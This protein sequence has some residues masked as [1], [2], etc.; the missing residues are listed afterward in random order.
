MIDGSRGGSSTV[1]QRAHN[2]SGPGSIPGRP[3]SRLAGIEG[4]RAV[5]ALSILVYHVYSFGGVLGGPGSK[6]TQ[7]HIFAQLQLGVTLFFALS[8]F[9]LYRPFAAA[10]LDGRPLPSLR[11]YARNRGL[12]IFPAYWVVLTVVTFV[13]GVAVVRVGEDGFGV[14]IP[15][16]LADA[17]LVQDFHPSGILTGIA[18]AWSLAVELG[19]YVALPLLVL[20]AARLARGAT[21]HRERLGAVLTP[22]ALMLAVGIVSREVSSRVLL[23]DQD[24]YGFRESWHAVLER[25]IL[26]NADLFAA[27]LAVAVIHAEVRSGRLTVPR[28]VR[29]ALLAAGAAAL[30]VAVPTLVSGDLAVRH[31]NTLS[32]LAV[33][34]LLAAVVLRGPGERRPPLLERRALVNL[35]LISYGVFLW[36]YPIVFFLRERGWNIEDPTWLAFA[37]N[38]AIVLGITL[39]LAALTYRFVE[40]PALA[41]KRRVEPPTWN[42]AA[43]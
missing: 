40:K 5:A 20:L 39:T 13:L 24:P 11:A 22:A 23:T 32:S 37:G 38:L 9:L 14:H 4:L 29:I 3:T 8:A 12:R 36:H 18:P 6:W 10:I 33:T 43:P 30:A 28:R 34:A 27:G 42:E 31:F 21:T 26:V 7:Q 16:F 17:L 2:P 15:T 41:R 35:G 25:S 19:F 1:E